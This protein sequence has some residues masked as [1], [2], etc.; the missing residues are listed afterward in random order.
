[1]E[2][3]TTGDLELE[4]AAYDDPDRESDPAETVRGQRPEVPAQ[5]PEATP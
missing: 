4:P 3:T 2:K 1:V 5:D